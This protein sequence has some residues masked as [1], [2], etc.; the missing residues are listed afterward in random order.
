[1]LSAPPLPPSLDAP[2]AVDRAIGWLAGLGFTCALFLGLAHLENLGPREA[3]VEFD[4]L[5]AVSLPFSPPPPPPT[6]LDQPTEAPADLPPLAGLEPG[7]SDSPVRIAV[8]PADLEA[9]L[10]PST[11]P[12]RAAVKFGQLHAEMKPRVD[13]EFEPQHV[14]QTAEV[15]QAPR[16]VVREVPAVPRELFPESRTLRVVLLLVIDQQGRAISARVAETSGQ[17]TFDSI[18]AQTVM[19][20]WEF[21]PAIRRGKKVKCLAQQAF[22]INLGARSRFEAR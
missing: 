15:D 4:D 9:L 7:A 10:P 2:R 5:R 19:D 16:A 18:V 3:P 21:S 14:F 17:P 12:P 11:I 20:A 22:R 6:P 13:L 8:V 1:M